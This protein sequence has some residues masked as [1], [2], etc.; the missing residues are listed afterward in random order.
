MNYYYDNFVDYQADFDLDW[1]NKFFE[2]NQNGYI[3]V[4]IKDL[5]EIDDAGFQYSILESGKRYCII[6]PPLP[7]RN[8]A[9][10]IDEFVKELLAE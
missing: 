6:T 8:E 1:L 3:V 2:N 7:E 9:E 4:K 10:E 5:K